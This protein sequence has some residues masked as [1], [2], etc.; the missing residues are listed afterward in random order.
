MYKKAQIQNMESLFVVIILL[1]IIIFGIFFFSQAEKQDSQELSRHFNELDD[2]TK[3]Q[4]VSSLKELSCSQYEVSQT[5]CF[6]LHK[7]EIFNKSIS[8]SL[9]AKEYYYTSFGKATI[10]IKQI[11]PEEKTFLLYNNTFLENISYSSRMT[12]IPINLF[13]AIDLSYTFALLEIQN[14]RRVLL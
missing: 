7:V 12:I 10:Q 6:D 9:K 1:I 14:Y 3:A 11:Y 5:S 2:I 13:N 4:I 8:E